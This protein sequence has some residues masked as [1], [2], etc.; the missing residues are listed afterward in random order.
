[1]NWECR[2][3]RKDAEMTVIGPGAGVAVALDHPRPLFYSAHLFMK[4]IVGI[5]LLA[6]ALGVTG[7]PATR[8][9]NEVA[10]IVNDDVITYKDVMIRSAQAVQL[11]R[12]Q[13]AN[14][15]SVLEQKIKDLERDALEELVERKLILHEF[16]TAG[17]NL[18]DSIIE[19]RVKERIRLKYGDRLTLTRSLQEDGV[20]YASFRERIREDFIITAMRSKNISQEIIISPHKLEKYY[21]EN[22]EKFKVP[23][24]VKLRMIMLNKPAAGGTARKLAEEILAKLQDGAS[25]GEMAGVY[26]DGLHKSE[27]GDY[28][29]IDRKVLRAEL[30]DAAFALQPGQRS[31][32]IEVGDTCYILLV[33]GVKANHVQT[34]PEVREEIQQTLETTER[35]RLRKQWMARLKAKSFVLYFPL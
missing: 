10:V 35:E 18:P 4:R 7:R 5:V 24:Q 8:V 21:A 16:K 14:Q 29:W 25:F 13:F 28:G 12:S 3:T 20:T 30:T 26:S 15:P 31:Q 17:Y 9:A 23:D 32:I 33:E 22:L 1:M 34:L 11:L 19:D 27:G 6:L 2:S